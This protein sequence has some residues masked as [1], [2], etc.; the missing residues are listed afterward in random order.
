MHTEQKWKLDTPNFWDQ[1]F[2]IRY[3]AMIFFF[4][5]IKTT[6]H[7]DIR[8]DRNKFSPV[9]C[10]ID[11]MSKKSGYRQNKIHRMIKREHLC[12][13]LPWTTTKGER[14]WAVVTSW[15]G[16][17][18]FLFAH[19]RSPLV[20]VQGVEVLDWPSCSPDLNPIE[21]IWNKLDRPVRQQVNPP[22]SLGDLECALVEHWRHL[23]KAAFTN[24]LRCMRRHCVAVRDARGGHNWYWKHKCS[25]LIILW[26]L[27]WP[28]P[29]FFDVY[30]YN[31]LPV[32][33]C[34]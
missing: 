5:C 10:C 29:D 2:N 26:I 33:I 13:K 27:F 16:V 24:I 9:G 8:R 3:K 23:P 30:Q 20:V 11:Q 31:N 28:Y 22:Q 1:I 32:R 15:Y 34:S 18:F 19:G 14:K 6:K 17:V 21:H 12:F 25:L 4:F 7:L